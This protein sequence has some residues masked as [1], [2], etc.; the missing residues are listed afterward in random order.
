[1]AAITQS[2]VGALEFDPRG[3]SAAAVPSKCTVGE[4]CECAQTPANKDRG[5]R[6]RPLL[7][8]LYKKRSVAT[9]LDKYLRGDAISNYPDIDP[10]KH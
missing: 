10:E 8:V 3:V 9:E 5:S 7:C 1:M 6:F 4:V 2:R